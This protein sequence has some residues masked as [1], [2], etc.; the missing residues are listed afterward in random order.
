MSQVSN[1]FSSFDAKGIRESLA[2]VIYSLSPEE[3]PFMSNIS[4]ESISNTF[5]EWQTDAL[6]SA[7]AANAAIDGDDIS[8][9]TAVTATVRP[10]NRTQISRKTFIIADNLAFQDLAGRNSEI[11]YQVTKQGKELKRDMEAVLTANVIPAAGSSSAAR[12]CGGLS[13]WL[14]TNSVSNTGSSG[15]AGAN[16]VLTAGIPTTVQTEA[17]NKRAATEALLKTV[18]SN[19]WTNGGTP[20]LVMCGAALKQV[21]SGFAGIAAQ[22]YQAPAAP[23]TIV[24]AA[25][26]Y[27]SDFGSVS[28]VPNRF[29]PTRNVFVLDPE[30]A[31]MGILRDIQTQELAKTGDASKY[32]M[33]A[34]YTLI[35]K[36]EKAHGAIYDCD[37]T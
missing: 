33:L 30:Y 3:T 36:N 31:G 34:E 24:G 18:I 11:A 22:R 20:T 16:P 15:T 25:D 28:I 7:N 4:S 2:D 37:D 27:V 6:A 10:G 35:M 8:S 12:R 29:S 5:T 14:A 26:V 21:I 32:L 13:A 23:T 17:T 9:F 19:V 1:T